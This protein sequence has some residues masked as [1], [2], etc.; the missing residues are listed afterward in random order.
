MA[1]YDYDIVVIGSGVGGLTCGALL[2]KEGLKVLILE[3][4]ERIGGCCSNYDVDGFQPDVG[5]IFVI[6]HEMYYKLFELLDLRLED[7]LD[8]RLMDPVYDTVLEDGERILL[9]RDIDEMAEVVESISPKDVAGYYRYCD[10]MKKLFDV[11]LSS[12][13]VPM[14]DLKHV[15]SLSHMARMM[16]RRE[17]LSALPVNLRLATRSLAKV[18]DSYFSDERIRLIFGWENLY[19]ALP[20]YRCTGLLSNITYMG[21]RGFHYPKG[22]MI[23]I[24]KALRKVTERFGGEV[25]LNSLV[26]R[27]LVKDGKAEGVRVAGGEEISA[28]AVI[29]NVHSRTT[30]LDLVG[31]EHLP[32][33]VRRA[34]KNQ[35]CSMPAPT[36]YMG[37]SE[38]MDSVR[39]H[40]TA[41]LTGR[42]KFDNLFPEFYD[43]GL[44]YRP[45][46]GAFLVS[47]AS[48][49]D[50]DLAPEGKQV[51]SVIYIAPYRLK[52][53]RWDDIADEWAWECIDSLEKRAFPG[54]RSKVEWMDSVTP[55]E[56]ERR[57]RLPE[58]AFFGLEMSGSNLGPFRP[59]YRSKAIDNLYLTGQCTNPGGGVPLVMIS[60]ISTSSLIVSDWPEL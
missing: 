44:L 57:L 47:C 18:V 25:R 33:V 23:A 42:D 55:V 29:S 20:A 13:S 3:Q 43:K 40:M 7:Y 19:A 32:Y 31:S 9:P 45:D 4:S 6:G 16:T 38:K 59:S 12:L 39:A 30:Y 28:R 5:A 58:G 17:Q 36:F 15:T 2:S 52:Y 50:P 41:V 51:L 37:L 35:P 46:D 24:P 11:Y 54:L 53:H 48:H 27:I 60:G 1:Q 21:R 10:D 49:G 14:P 34:V 8:F 56:L 26:D 22:G